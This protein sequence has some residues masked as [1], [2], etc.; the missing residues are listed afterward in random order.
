MLD[1]FQK[2]L[3]QTV[4]ENNIKTTDSVS[5]DIVEALN[6]IGRIDDA[7]NLFPWDPEDLH[8]NLRESDHHDNMFRRLQL[9]P[10]TRRGNIIRKMMAHYSLQIILNNNKDNN[11]HPIPILTIPFADSHEAAKLIS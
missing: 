9:L 8:Y 3:W 7:S 4:I 10:Q 11:G 1:G 2:D 5:M 6:I